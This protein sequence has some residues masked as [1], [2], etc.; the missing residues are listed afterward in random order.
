M[1]DFS[2]LSC[3]I[4]LPKFGFNISEIKNDFIFDVCFLFNNIGGDDEE[5]EDIDD[6]LEYVESGEDRNSWWSLAPMIK[7]CFSCFD[8]YNTH[9]LSSE[10]Q[11]AKWWCK[12]LSLSYS[13]VSL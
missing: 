9:F 11:I 4:W 5:N 1:F 3:W 7:P 13:L 2:I 8:N 6:D 12:L 10:S